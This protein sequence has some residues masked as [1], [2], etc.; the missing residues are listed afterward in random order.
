LF[1]RT[2]Y[3][4]GSLETKERKKGKEV[5]E[6]RYYEIDSQGSRQRRAITVGTLDEYPTESAA[7]KSSLVQAV[8]LRINAEQP[9]TA[10]T[11]LC[12]AVIARYEQE[13]MP[14]RYSTKAAYQSYI[15]NHIRPR[16]T[17]TPLNAVKPMAVEDWLKRLDLAPKTRGHIRSLMHTIFQCAERW[18]LTEKNPMKLVR[19]RDATKRL[20]TP[21]VLT[22]DEFHTLLPLIREPYRT[23]V[24]VAGCLGL[25][26]SEIVAL[27][28]A[29][30]DFQEFTLLVQRSIVHGRVGDV[31]TEYSRDS[32]PL[33]PALAQ[34][35][36]QHKE[37][38]FSTPEGWLFANP[39]T[40]RPY[41]QEEIQK[42]HLRKAGKAAGLGDKIGWHTFRHSYRSWLDDTGAPLTVQKEL[43]RHAS[44]QTTM[45]VY[46][47]A[48]TDTKRQAHSK[49][50]EM[51]MRSKN[52]RRLATD[53]RQLSA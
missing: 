11:T 40:G 2:R 25:R 5:W 13:E 3:Q 17:D 27:Q 47:K 24:L 10:V 33:D 34:A 4:Y 43:M 37:R 44:I 49:V 22:P 9:A 28:W 36:M 23:M 45:N 53:N 46:G 32:V 18:E 30:F 21:R 52:S 1:T 31:K 51:V 19:V 12:G 20:Q 42:T 39:V 38:A 7:R 35:L 8:L 14:E 15:D 50:V 29:D 16:W 41:H 48:M 6:F 26:V